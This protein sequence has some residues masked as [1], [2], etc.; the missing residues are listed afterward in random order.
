M[1]VNDCFLLVC[2]K[3]AAVMWNKGWNVTDD[4]W[5]SVSHIT[6]PC[7]ALGVKELILRALQK[8]NSCIAQQAVGCAVL[9]AA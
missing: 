8:K 5:L 6:A 2:I 9:I 4:F 7:I 3:H 1:L